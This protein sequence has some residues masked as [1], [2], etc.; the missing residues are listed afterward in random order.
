MLAGRQQQQHAQQLGTSNTQAR[1]QP[2]SPAAARAAAGPWGPE[3]KFTPFNLRRW[4]IM[5]DPTPNMGENDASLSLTL[6]A[7]RRV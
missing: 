3:I 5:P 6:F 7:A 4:E 2:V 1:Q